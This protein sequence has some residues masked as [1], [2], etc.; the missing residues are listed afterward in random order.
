[1]TGRPSRDEVVERAI[2]S[3]SELRA[4]RTDRPIAAEPL[5][6]AAAKLIDVGIFVPI[7]LL[8]LGLA[9][10]LFG[11]KGDTEPLTMEERLR[12]QRVNEVRELTRGGAIFAQVGVGV[13]A[14]AF[15]AHEA[16][17]ASRSRQSFGRR[18]LGIYVVDVPAGKKVSPLRM[19]ARY[20]AG[21]LPVGACLLL[22]IAGFGSWVGSLGTLLVVG[23]LL[24]V[25]GLAFFRDDKRGLH[26]LMLG[27]AAVQ[28]RHGEPVF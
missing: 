8:V 26:D 25:P 13:V 21:A 10:L 24:A 18:K 3:F 22:A 9:A 28:S 4:L 5:A 23:A 27:T 2:A 11:F 6:R 14:L 16:G 15:L 19:I 12:G 1:M 17:M 20:L 7:V